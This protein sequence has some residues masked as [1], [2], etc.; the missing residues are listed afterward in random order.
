MLEADSLSRVNM[1]SEHSHRIPAELAHEEGARCYA[2]Q[3]QRL[4]ASDIAV[5]SVGCDGHAAG[6]FP[7]KSIALFAC[8]EIRR[9]YL[10]YVGEI[11]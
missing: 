7:G 4:Q 2:Q 6:L 11:I 9:K 8:F 10:V 5:L 1:P 3:L